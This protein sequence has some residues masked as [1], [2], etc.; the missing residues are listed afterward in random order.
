MMKLHRLYER[1]MR[2]RRSWQLYSLGCSV[3]ELR[4]IA[5]QCLDEGLAS[6]SKKLREVAEALN[7]H[8]M[9]ERSVN[10]KG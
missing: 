3:R 2:L 7:C 4:F 6:Q 5:E 8:W 9:L 1:I 10:K